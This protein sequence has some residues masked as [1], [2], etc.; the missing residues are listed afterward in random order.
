MRLTKWTD[1]R[2]TAYH[3][4]LKDYPKVVDFAKQE[5]L[6]IAIKPVYLAGT[7]INDEIHVTLTRHTTVIESTQEL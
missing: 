6:L 2:Y 7:I 4:K 1:G 3:C 5:G